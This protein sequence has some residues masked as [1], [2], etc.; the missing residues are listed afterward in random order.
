MLFSIIENGEVI[1]RAEVIKTDLK[2]ADQSCTA[3]GICNVLTIPRAQ[4]RGHGKSVISAA[5]N[6]ILH[7]GADMGLLF[8]TLQLVPFYAACGWK[9][10]N[11]S[12]TRI[13]TPTKYHACTNARMVLAVSD[14]GKQACLFFETNPMHI[15]HAW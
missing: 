2:H 8:C 1:S 12:D 13:G 4:G 3:Y 14:K 5:T 6:Y 11:K 7:S 15:P 9:I 10:S